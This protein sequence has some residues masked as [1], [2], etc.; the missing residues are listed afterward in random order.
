M[1]C[2]R[3]RGHGQSAVRRLDRDRAAVRRCVAGVDAQVEHRVL[4]LA[5]IDQ[6][7][8]Q[9][10]GTDGLD[11]DRRTDGAPDQLVHAGHEL[12]DVG[13][14][15]RERLAAREREQPMGQR[16]G[17][18]GRALRGTDVAI[19]L[20][21]A[22]LPDADLQQLEAAGDPG[23]QVVEVVR[24]AAGQL[25]DGFHLLRLPQRVLRRLE[26]RLSFLLVRDMAPRRVDQVRARRGD[27][28]DPAIRPVAVPVTV[29]DGRQRAAGRVGQ[30]ALGQCELVG[31]HEP[32]EAHADD[33]RL[34]ETEDRL[35]RRVRATE[36]ARRVQHGHEVG[37]R[38]PQ[39]IALRRAFG[40]RLGLRMLVGHVAR[41]AVDAAVLRD[42]D[43]RQPAMAAVL[44]AIAIDEAQHRFAAPHLVHSRVARDPVVGIDEVGVR[45][46]DELRRRPS[47]RVGPRRVDLDDATRL[48]VEH[49]Q[50]VRAHGPRQARLACPLGD[51]FEVGAQLPHFGV[52]RR[53]LRDGTVARRERATQFHLRHHLPRERFERVG[54]HRRQPAGPRFGVDDAQHADRDAVRRREP[55]AG[56]ETQVRRA[57]DERVVA[58]ARIAGQVLDDEQAGSREPEP[59]DRLRQR[60]LAG[61]EP[62]PR[63]EPLAIVGDEADERDRRGAE[64][65]REVDDV[66]EARFR[67]RVEDR[68]VGQRRDAR[69]GR[70]VD[71][72]G[73]LVRRDAGVH[74]VDARF[75]I[76]SP[77]T[78]RASSRRRRCAASRSAAGRPRIPGSPRRGSTARDTCG[79]GR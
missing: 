54:L 39:V 20:G 10:V 45:R 18:S 15:R 22:A 52:R 66:V 74:Q 60:R 59:A 57:G 32:V 40:Q 36:R 28:R 24:E 12:S 51:A 27:P 23:E 37:R 72:R 75:T 4:E 29:L 7:R 5:R 41:A 34:V 73:S 61:V 48:D 77:R 49:R 53:S 25:A 30:R 14:L 58:R 70:V 42:G 68:V 9:V 35:P 62:D 67:R 38:F 17:T 71:R 26:L 79:T 31:M 46:A 3:R 76:T 56:V 78:R 43:P 33:V 69:R 63:L 65:S 11:A 2:E 50:Q 19:D 47:E 44:A 64:I 6:A 13:R 21:D 8:P 1:P 55:R 16:R